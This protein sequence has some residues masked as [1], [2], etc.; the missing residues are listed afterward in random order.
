[1]KSLTQLFAIAGAASIL[2]ANAWATPVP[3]AEYTFNNSLDSTIGGAPALTAVDPLHLSG[4]RTDTVFGATRSVYDF[5]GGSMA[6]EQAGLALDVSG[7]LPDNNNY[8][9]QMQFKFD[10][11]TGYRRIL[12][13]SNRTMDSGFYVDPY[14]VLQVYPYAGATTF[15]SGVYHDVVLSN[16]NGKVTWY[17]D[18]GVQNTISTSVMDISSAEMLNFFLDNFTGA[19]YEYSTGS[20][21]LIRV[22]DRALTASDVVDLPSAAVPEPATIALLA[23]GIAAFALARRRAKKASSA[24]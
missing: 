11:A 1:M 16:D 5:I 22:F 19:S 13:T 9:V 7:L 15:T 23:P 24:R 4:F 2:T 20:V 17:M 21:A 6:S 12:D 3:V 10:K 14:N 8:A 18:G